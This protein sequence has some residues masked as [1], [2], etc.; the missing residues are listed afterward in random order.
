[1]G[2]SF[3]TPG[4]P[5]GR[6]WPIGDGA[7]ANLPAVTDESKTESLETALGAGLALAYG[8][9]LVGGTPAL[10]HY[11]SVAKTT[12]LFIL[13]GDGEWNALEKLWIDTV[14]VDETDTGLVHFHPGKDGATGTEA[15]PGTPNQQICSFFPAGNTGTTFSRTAYLGLLIPDDPASTTTGE[16][17]DVRGI[18]QTRKVRIFDASGAETSFAYSANPAWCL[19]DAFISF[20]LKPHGTVDEA[21]TAAE[22]LR[23]DFAAFMDAADYCDADIGGGIARFES[24]IF[25]K[26]VTNL[27]KIFETLCATCRGYMRENHGKLG[28]YIDQP[29]TSIFTFDTDKIV[30]GSFQT[31]AQDLRSTVNRLVVKI[32]DIAS[33]GADPSK[34]FAPFTKTLDAEWH[35]EQVGRAIKQE[36]D[37]G[38]NTKERSERVGAYWLNRSL[39]D[40]GT[41]FAATQDAGAVMPGDRVLGPID[42]GLVNAGDWEVIEITDEPN[43]SRQVCPQ[44]YDADIFSDVAGP[45]QDAEETNIPATTQKTYTGIDVTDPMVLAA[46]GPITIPAGTSVDVPTSTGLWT[47]SSQ[48]GQGDCKVGA[49]DEPSG[50][51]YLETSGAD[52]DYVQLS[53]H[54][55]CIDLGTAA[56]EGMFSAYSYSG[57]LDAWVMPTVGLRSPDGSDYA[58]AYIDYPNWWTITGTGGLY[59]GHDS[60][61]ALDMNPRE[62]MIQR[63]AGGVNFYI[64][65]AGD[66]GWTLV[67]TH[68]TYIPTALLSPFFQVNVI[69]A[70]AE[71][72]VIGTC[73][74]AAKMV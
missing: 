66:T 24:H 52:N 30:E 73:R 2:S 51:V 56:N 35:Q 19:L 4:F 6:P 38:A 64:K 62:W 71:R 8:R 15:V 31:S 11:D 65:I 67:A 33:G 9:H 43:G 22:K 37:L 40:S 45:Q 17:V 26:E 69:G 42:Q 61:I 34:D 74:Y 57:S 5:A 72:L 27:K 54:T 48:P 10:Y 29:R 3:D 50:E 59:E 23:I 25:F 55:P 28:L 68:T 1:M 36:I 12:A 13:L 49:T 16:K 44:E 20:Y 21:L 14:L 53:L 18:Y 46:A 41:Q 39:L 70:H 32:R 47:A 58:F 60:G 7:G 63:D